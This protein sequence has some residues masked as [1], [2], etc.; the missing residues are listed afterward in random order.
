M[1]KPDKQLLTIG[2]Y[3]SFEDSSPMKHE[4]VAG[5]VYALAGATRRHNRIAVNIC[6]ALLVASRG[7][8]C[9]VSIS[10]V[11]LRAA[12]D[13]FY[14]PD[15]MVACGP[16]PADAMSEDAPCLIVEVTSPSTE[17]VDVREKAL[18]YKR[19]QSMHAYLIVYQDVRHVERHW[20]DASGTWQY[21]SVGAA[22]AVQ[23]HCPVLQLT[24][25]EIYEGTDV[26]P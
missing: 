8:K 10:D 2:E 7:G 21:E 1:A 23:I 12:G 9:R 6:A 13:V 19:I 3:L 16:E 22:S 20:R 17:S 14:Y 25:D 5:E 15:V 24:L 26:Q 11:R 4:Y 18:I